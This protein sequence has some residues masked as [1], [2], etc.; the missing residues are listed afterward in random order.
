[1]K[2]GFSPFCSFPGTKVPKKGG[3]VALTVS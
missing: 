1:L 3:W 2:W